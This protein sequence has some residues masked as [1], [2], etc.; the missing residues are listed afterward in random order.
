MFHGFVCFGENIC[1]AA[2]LQL[3]DLSWNDSLVSLGLTWLGYQD[4]VNRLLQYKIREIYGPLQLS[5]VKA[6]KDVKSRVRFCL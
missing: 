1:F 5:R 4:L 3:E 2:Y 6:V